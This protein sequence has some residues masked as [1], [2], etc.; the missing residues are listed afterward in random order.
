[1]LPL[2]EFDSAKISSKP[3]APSTAKVVP[4]YQRNCIYLI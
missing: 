1:L 3:A 4:I 2:P